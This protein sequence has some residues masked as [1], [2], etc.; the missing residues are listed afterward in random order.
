M[1][2]LVIG[3]QHFKVDNIDQVEIFIDKLKEYLNQNTFDF[4]VFFL[5]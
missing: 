1:K 4:I 2:G 3:D 5:F